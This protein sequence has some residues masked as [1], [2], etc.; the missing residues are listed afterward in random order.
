MADLSGKKVLMIIAS[1]NFR[2]EEYLEPRQIF[3]SHGMEVVT[4]SSK[5]G[6]LA[7]MMGATAT[8][9]SEIGDVNV[10]DFDAVVFVGGTGAAEYFDN[11]R[12]HAIATEAHESGKVLAAICIAPSILANAGVLQGR[13]ATAYSSEQQNLES[14][15]ATYTGKSVTR[16]GSIITAN[17]PGA[18]TGFGNAIVHALSG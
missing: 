5:T 6:E 1:Q 13:Q 10:S 17:G 11:A 2:D 8:A 3:E 16:D 14:H 9:G 15:G 7:G 4:A 18:A 12:A